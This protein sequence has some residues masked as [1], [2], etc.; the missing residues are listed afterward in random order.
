VSAKA[1]QSTGGAYET[2]CPGPGSP[3]TAAPFSPAGVSNVSNART[4]SV[5]CA[6]VPETPGQQMENGMMRWATRVGRIRG[7]HTL[8]IQKLADETGGEVLKDKP[9]NLTTTFTR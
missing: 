9:E 4:D 5:V 6:I 1:T 3:F 2:I 7:V 8:D